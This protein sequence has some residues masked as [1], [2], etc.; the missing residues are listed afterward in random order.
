[1][2]ASPIAKLLITEPADA[3][4]AMTEDRVYRKA[5]SIEGALAELRRCNGTQ[6]MPAAVD[7][8]ETVVARGGRRR[9]R[10]TDA[11]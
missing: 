5:M 8:L 7:A 9:V 3:Y 1:M 11:A 4:H 6:F 2:I 10:F